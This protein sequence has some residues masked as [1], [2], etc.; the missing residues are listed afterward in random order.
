MPVSAFVLKKQRPAARNEW[1][2]FGVIRADH[3]YITT[4]IFF[5]KQI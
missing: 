2:A 4:G 5:L 3:E 1:L